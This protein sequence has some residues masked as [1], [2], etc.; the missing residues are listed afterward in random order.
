MYCGTS[1]KLKGRSEWEAYL[2]QTNKICFCRYTIGFQINTLLKD[3]YITVLQCI[4]TVAVTVSIAISWYIVAAVLCSTKMWRTLINA[5]FAG[6]SHCKDSSGQP[7]RSILI[8]T[9]Q[10]MVYYLWRPALIV[11]I[12]GKL[13]HWHGFETRLQAEFLV[14]TKSFQYTQLVLTASAQSVIV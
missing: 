3:S 7:S 4:N 11:S 12:P 1:R 8:S 9:D 14:P 5:S 13:F 10:R 2:W 6:S